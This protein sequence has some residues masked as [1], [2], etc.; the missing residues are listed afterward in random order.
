MADRLEADAELVCQQF[1][2]VAA[3]LGRTQEAHVRHHQGASEIV[4]QTDAGLSDACLIGEAGTC[5]H[6]I[7]LRQVAVQ[8]Q[9]GGHLECLLAWLQVVRQ[10]QPPCF[11]IV[12]A[13][14]AP[15]LQRGHFHQHAVAV[16]QQLAQA[17]CH[18]P[19]RQPPL[20][21]QTL[22]QLVQFG[23]VVVHAVEELT[24]LVACGQD[25]AGAGLAQLELQGGGM[26]TQRQVAAVQIQQ[27]A[28]DLRQVAGQGAQLGR[29]DLRQAQVA[30]G[31]AQRF[32]QR[33]R[34]IFVE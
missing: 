3:G 18:V 6:R 19:G 31:F 32:L 7:D 11:G 22:G 27:G 24:H 1:D 13:L 9:L 25:A 8:G 15:G 17:W 20:G 2:V 29:A 4:R 23:N 5:H 16:G 33:G 30:Q 21:E 28:A 34:L 10:P 12:L 14:L 26:L